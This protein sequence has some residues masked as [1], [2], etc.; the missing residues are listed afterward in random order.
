MKQNPTSD[1]Q[2][3][4]KV[5]S[6]SVPDVETTSKQSCTTLIQRC[7]NIVQDCFD[8]LQRRFNVVSTLGTDVV[9]MLCIVVLT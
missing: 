8:V 4:H 6:A 7:I 1:F 2:R 9:S 3:C 5:D